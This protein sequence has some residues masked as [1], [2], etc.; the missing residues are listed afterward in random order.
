MRQPKR[1][2]I[3]AVAAISVDALSTV[4][5]FRLLNKLKGGSANIRCS[6]A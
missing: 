1:V 4:F 2:R 5:A 6:F 3:C